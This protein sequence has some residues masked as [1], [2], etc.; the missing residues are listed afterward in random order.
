Y[1]GLK[2][3][4]KRRVLSPPPRQQLT[5]LPRR[6]VG[7]TWDLH[8]DVAADVAAT[9]HPLTPPLTGGPAVVD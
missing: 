6:Q 8:A 4:Q 9:W 3:K 1:K 2:T 5:W 7:L